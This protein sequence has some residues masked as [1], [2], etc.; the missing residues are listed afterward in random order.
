MAS[1]LSVSPGT[2]SAS[3]VGSVD[4]CILVAGVVAPVDYTICFS[5]Y[6]HHVS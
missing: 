2:S 1:V 5:A 6:K 3:E 4:N